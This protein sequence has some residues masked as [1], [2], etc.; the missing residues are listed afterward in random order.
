MHHRRNLH[1]YAGF[2]N[3]IEQHLATRRAAGLFDFSFM[4]LVEIA[5]PA[6]LAFLERLQTRSIARLDVGRIVYT[7]LLNDNGSVFIDATLWRISSERWWLFTGR[8][9]DTAFV[10][11]RAGEGGVHVRDRSDA[12]AVLALQG[13]ESGRQLA[14]AV[15]ATAVQNLRYF[16]LVEARFGAIDCVVG[17]LGYSGELGYE[18]V[19]PIADAASL[20]NALLDRGGV[21][22]GFDA[23]NSLRIESGYVLFDREVTGREDPFELGLDRLVDLDGRDFLG[24]DAFIALRRTPP[25]RR[26]VGLEIGDHAASSLLPRADITS[27]CDSPIF[28]RRIGLGFA[29]MKVSDGSRVRLDDGRLATIARLP[30][31]DSPRCLPRSAPL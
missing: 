20:R 19:V 26:L 27:E 23:A 16:R 15:G 29:P 28:R 17:R 8:R 9:S 2:V 3:S 24:R 31:Y 12:F 13:P 22:C 10:E 5:G 1:A 30:F 14:V 25:E 11:A 7:L 18:I 21:A 4:N 6:A